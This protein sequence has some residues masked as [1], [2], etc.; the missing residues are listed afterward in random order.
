[1]YFQ[2]LEILNT[3]FTHKSYTNENLRYVQHNERL[4]FLGDSVL[5]LITVEILY[6]QFPHYDEGKLSRIKSMLVSEKTLSE[7]ARQLHLSQYLLVGKGEKSSGGLS[8]DSNLANLLEAFLGAIYLDQ[9]FSVAKNWLSPFLQKYIVSLEEKK[10]FKDSKSALQEWSQKKFK[11]VPKY[12]ILEE[13]GPDHQKK[14]LIEVSVLKY[15]AIGEGVTKRK[16][17][18][19]AAQKLLFMLKANKK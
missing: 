16:A 6:A 17:E 9:G 15:K 4:E 5:S 1:M 19:D 18:A 12:T 14:F 8:R 3:A 13:T 2:D 11:I 7:I 10:Q